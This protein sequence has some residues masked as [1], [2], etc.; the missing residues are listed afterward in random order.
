MREGGDAEPDG[1]LIEHCHELGDDAFFFQSLTT[2]ADLRY[3]EMN[4]LAQISIRG[5]AVALQ[6]VEEEQ[7]I[8]VKEDFLHGCPVFC[9]RLA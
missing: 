4:G 5:V 8:M 9:V 1:F 2:A 6:G 3:R 7:V